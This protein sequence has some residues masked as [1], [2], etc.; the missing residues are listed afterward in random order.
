MY[1]QVVAYIDWDS[2][3]VGHPG[4]DLGWSRLEAALAYSPAAADEITHGWATVTGQ[5]PDSLAYWDLVA[6]LQTHADL[7]SHTGKRDA[8]LRAALARMEDDR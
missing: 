2:A 6:A 3:R 1:D 5:G 7:G 8:F 4:I